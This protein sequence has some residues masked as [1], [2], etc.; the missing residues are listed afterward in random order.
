MSWMRMADKKQS[1][2]YDGFE[3]T[4]LLLFI[5]F[6]DAIH[7][8]NVLITFSVTLLDVWTIKEFDRLFETNKSVAVNSSVLLTLEQFG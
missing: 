1:Q 5:H 2:F 6:L 3:W 8:G 7:L 4:C